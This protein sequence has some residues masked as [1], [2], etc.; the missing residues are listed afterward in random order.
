[1]CCLITLWHWQ[2]L[3]HEGIA[4]GDFV[5]AEGLAAGGMPAGAGCGGAGGGA[6]GGSRLLRRSDQ[7]S[8]GAVLRVMTNRRSQWQR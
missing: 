6:G 2:V 8:E 5:R 7:L 3:R 4:A 1:M